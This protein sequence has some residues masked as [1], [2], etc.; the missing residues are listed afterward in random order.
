LVIA[1]FFSLTGSPFAQAAQDLAGDYELTGVM[2]M[3]GALTLKADHTYAAGFS[4]GAADWVEAGT[5]K[6][7][8][9]EVAL[10]GSHFK[11]KNAFKLPLFLPGG[12]RLHYDE[13]KLTAT[14]PG[15]SVTFLNPNKTPSHRKK[16]GEAGE[17]RMLVRGHVVKLDAESLVVKTKK[18]GCIDFAVSRLSPEVL[19]K[20]KLGKRIDAE[21]PY[22]AIIGGESCPE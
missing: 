20:A 10:S 16:T 12:T 8:G 13:G 15:G 17:G 18:D 9:D 21:I 7:E 2:E 1:I 6:V 14:G 4:Y 22:S 19:T 5:W 11:T 3:A